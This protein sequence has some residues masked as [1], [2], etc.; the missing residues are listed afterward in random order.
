LSKS[1]APPT[2]KQVPQH[3]LISSCVTELDTW[4]Y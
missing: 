1:D 3:P 4:Q 2:S